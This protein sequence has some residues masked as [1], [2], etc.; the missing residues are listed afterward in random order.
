MSFSYGCRWNVW[1]ERKRRCGPAPVGDSSER[2][3]SDGDTGWTRRVM[4]Q[5]FSTTAPAC[6]MLSLSQQ[7]AESSLPPTHLRT[8]YCSA[9][10]GG[11]RVW[12]W[13][14]RWSRSRI[15][16]TLTIG[17]SGA[18][19]WHMNV[20][21]A[22]GNPFCQKLK[23]MLCVFFLLWLREKSPMQFSF[24]LPVYVSV[25]HICCNPASTT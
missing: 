12:W 17:V 20:W 2:T 16:Q 21:I 9:A 22:F 15:R 18:I 23:P 5:L 3:A 19:S 10:E 6:W 7:H 24:L 13:W 14:W 8:C 1:I 11:E 4:E 25:M